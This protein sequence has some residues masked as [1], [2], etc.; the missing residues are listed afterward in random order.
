[1]YAIRNV[2]LD[3]D[4]LCAWNPA[5]SHVGS[6]GFGGAYPITVRN[7]LKGE[8]VFIHPTPDVVR[9]NIKVPGLIEESTFFLSPEPSGTK[10]THTVNQRGVL[11][12]IIGNH[13]ASLV[14]H[15]RLARLTH[16]LNTTNSTSSNE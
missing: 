16:T 1:M 5:F 2:L 8:L 9:F 12:R 13:E 4:N 6:A 3:I 15:K 7:L 14:P 10:I 11:V